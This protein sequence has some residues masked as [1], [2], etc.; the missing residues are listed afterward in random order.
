MTQVVSTLTSVISDIKLD[1]V[2]S[3]V[4]GEYTT[5]KTKQRIR[6]SRSTPGSNGKKQ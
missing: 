3:P 1:Y 4:E 5:P 2:K 6:N